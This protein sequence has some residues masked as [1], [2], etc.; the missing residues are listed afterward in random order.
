[1]SMHRE[2]REREE[3]NFSRM[4]LCLFRSSCYVCVCAS[5]FCLS[6]LSFSFMMPCWLRYCRLARAPN[7]VEWELAVTW[8]ETFG[9]RIFRP[10]GWPA[11][12]WVTS[13][14]WIGP[15]PTL[16]S[17]KAPFSNYPLLA[18]STF[19]RKREDSG[20]QKKEREREKSLFC[21]FFIS[22][23]SFKSTD[24]DQ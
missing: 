10:R 1:M 4:M 3:E 23:L 24:L 19:F 17:L 6:H 8:R 2:K 22:R 16:N 21:L 7:P 9:G 11:D 18:M 13:G 12:G 14:V 15:R 5:S 20:E